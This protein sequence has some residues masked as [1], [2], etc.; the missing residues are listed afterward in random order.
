[1]TSSYIIRRT[2]TGHSGWNDGDWKHQPALQYLHVFNQC[3]N[4]I[5][6]MRAQPCEVR[7]ACTQDLFHYS[8]LLLN[9]SYL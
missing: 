9:L 8:Y 5:K 4:A 1:M 3:V 7:S 6:R 2:D